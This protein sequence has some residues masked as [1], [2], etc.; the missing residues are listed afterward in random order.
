[1]DELI[2][3]A[4]TRSHRFIIASTFSE[5]LEGNPNSIKVQSLI[6]INN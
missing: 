2:G 3:S 5:V 4:K 1:M 6:E